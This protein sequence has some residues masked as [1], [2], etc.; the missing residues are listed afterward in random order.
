M[1]KP[2][3]HLFPGFDGSSRFFGW[4]EEALAP[5]IDT[6]SHIIPRTGPQDY[7]FLV[8]HFADEI[9]APCYLLGES[10]SGPLTILL[11]EAFPEKVRGLVLSTTFAKTPFPP[12]IRDM[13]AMG[14]AW[15]NHMPF[16]KEYSKLFI[17]QGAD[18]PSAEEVEEVMGLLSSDI[19]QARTKACVH[20]DVS[21]RFAALSQPSLIINAR[22]DRVI[23]T[24]DYFPRKPANSKVVEFDCAHLLLQAMPKEAAN[25]I[26]KFIKQTE[27]KSSQGLHPIP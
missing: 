12:I 7:D 16:Q 24:G 20:V 1:T 21:D 11:A 14:A 8:K 27:S 2:L 13:M 5:K 18:N 19:V 26:G 3:L 22:H 17:L 23:G 25:E 9:D 10:F 6:R 4:L 15:R